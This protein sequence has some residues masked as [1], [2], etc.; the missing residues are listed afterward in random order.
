[1]VSDRTAS[2]LP[3]HRPTGPRT[4]FPGLRLVTT[5]APG[6]DR[7]RGLQ[8]RLGPDG[9]CVLGFSA[10]GVTDRSALG[11]DVRTRLPLDQHRALEQ[12]FAA[13]RCHDFALAVR[14]ADSL[15]TTLASSFGPHHRF[16]LS[17]AEVR[18]DV[19]WLSGEAWCAAEFW[20]L[21][22]EG[23]ARLE[24]P[25]SPLAHFGARQA[26]ASWW[27]V[28]DAEAAIGG[29]ALLAVLLLVTPGPDSDPVV[30]AVRR[31]MNRIALSA[32]GRRR[33][34]GA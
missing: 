20:I 25:T 26:A 14:R 4:A 29:T 11:A 3:P 31:R 22:A 34:T 15:L 16:T 32:P 1:M 6:A 5:D 13:A 8:L 33:R 30:R 17:A 19:A 9:R 18:A 28:P 2:D 27:E 23:W 21:I 10:P 24:G 12:V 7:D